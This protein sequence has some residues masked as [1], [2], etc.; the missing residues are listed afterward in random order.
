MWRRSGRSKYLSVR[1]LLV[2]INPPTTRSLPRP[3][4]LQLLIAVDLFAYGLGQA[5]QFATASGPWTTFVT[6]GLFLCVISVLSAA[7][8]Y[9]GGESARKALFTV[10]V[11]NSV[12]AVYEITV[13]LQ[14]G[15]NGF[16]AWVKV[17]VV[18]KALLGFVVNIWY[19]NTQE[20]KEYYCR[21]TDL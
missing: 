17:L 15:A 3:V 5:T 8:A 2:G 12:W 16:R 18:G 7:W 1:N 19:L 10:V 14:G 13:F 6:L 21:V 9:V 11:A 20:V 4:G